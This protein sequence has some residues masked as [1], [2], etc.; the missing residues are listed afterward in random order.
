MSKTTSFDEAHSSVAHPE[1][2]SRRVESQLLTSIHDGYSETAAAHV[3][4]SRIVT[5]HELAANLQ[6][7]LDAAKAP[8]SHQCESR[9]KPEERI[10]PVA[11]LHAL[12]VR[13]IRQR[14]KEIETRCP[15]HDDR[16]PS[17]SMN[18]E[19][20]QWYCHAGCGHGNAT[21]LVARILKIETRQ[22]HARLMEG[23][24]LRP[25]RLGAPYKRKTTARCSGSKTEITEQIARAYHFVRST[26]LSRAE[27]AKALTR[28]FGISRSTAYERLQVA[29]GQTDVTVQCQ[30][31]R[32]VRSFSCLRKVW[33]QSIRRLSC[34]TPREGL[35]DEELRTS[36]VEG[37]PVKVMKARRRHSRPRA[38]SILVPS[39]SGGKAIQTDWH[40]LFNPT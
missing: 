6:A 17:F 20:S 39:P 16:H 40:P 11:L 10:K 30:V 35:Q 34:A 15:F 23:D 25:V 9:S 33:T 4:P 1:S 7:R 13:A 5:A 22:A 21:T 38:P 26:Q 36:Q 37:E 19:T 28:Q 29:A 2:V 18:A 31:R 27:A 3:G 14:G 12:K 24:P 32:R 8:A